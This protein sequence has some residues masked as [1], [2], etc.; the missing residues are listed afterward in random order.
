M[1][2][3]DRANRCWR[4]V[5][6]VVALGMVLGACDDEKSTPTDVDTSVP[7][8]VTDIIASPKSADPGDTLLLSA[9]VVSSSPNESDI[10][11]MQ[12]SANGG[13]FLED[14]ETSVRWVAPSAGI[15][16]VTARAQNSVSSDADTADIFVGGSTSVVPNQGGTIR[17]HSNQTD[18]FYLKTV[19]NITAGVEVYGVV[20]GIR[21]DAVD[22][23]VELNGAVGQL[24]DYAPNLAF[25]VHA[26]D[27]VVLGATTPPVNLYLGDFGT[28]LYSRISVGEPNVDRFPACTDPDVAPDS[29][30]IAY[31]AMLPQPTA[32]NADSFDILVYDRVA[33]SHQKVTATHT[34]HRNVLPTWSTDQR[35]LTFISDRNGLNVWDLHGMPVTGGVINTAQASLVRLSNTGGE[36]ASGTLGS[37]T[38]SGPLMEWNPVAPTLAVLAKDGVFYLIATT[39]GGPSN[40]IDVG[41]FASGQPVD[42]AWSPDGSLLALST[43][44]EVL[45]LTTGGSPTSRV[46]RNG[47]TFNDVAWSPDGAWLVYRVLRGSSTWLEVYDLDGSTIAAPIPITEARPASGPLFSLGSYR[48]VMSVSPV[49]GTAGV[50]YYPA[51]PLLNPVTV[52]IFS[53]DVSGLTP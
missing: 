18:F 26:A 9:I 37:G 3:F 24:P 23:P 53:V 12:W 13:A 52:G 32:V 41:T 34:N 4:F 44:A 35:W 20:G 21:A 31:G 11:V 36:L 51:F 19:N 42:L 7:I 15:Y 22:N 14:D 6:V 50:L 46:K 17:L 48:D 38:F 49:W 28:K 39:P 30:Y 40:Q 45:T 5:V 43:G 1:K 27:S 33:L 29:R 2:T 47:D 8:Q 16:A 25:E 10:P